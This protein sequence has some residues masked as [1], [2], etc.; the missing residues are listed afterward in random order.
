ME[1]AELKA[2]QRALSKFGQKT[3]QRAA[4]LLIIKKRGYDTGRLS[5]SLDYDLHVA[6]NSIAMAFK[7]E[8]YGMAI[9]EGRKKSSRGSSPGE[10]YPKILEWVRR[11]GLRPRNSQ[12]QF[13]SWRNKDKQQ[14][15]IAYVVT[16]KIHRFGYKGTGFFD[17]AFK[18]N[19]KKLPK[20]LRKAFALDVQ[21]FLD[22][23]IRE[24]NKDYGNN[25]NRG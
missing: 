23:T 20:P 16:R 9:N 15:G 17:I 14:R 25:S 12:G 21:N 1:T 3:V 22:Y 13:E 11:K 18:E 6:A 5:K 7:M 10:L 8:D 24:I 2:T 4:S 19:F